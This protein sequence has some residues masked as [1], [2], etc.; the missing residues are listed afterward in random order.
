MTAKR[1]AVM[2]V[3]RGIVFLN[4]NSLAVFID[5]MIFGPGV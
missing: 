2:P 5:K 1:P 3:I 4:P